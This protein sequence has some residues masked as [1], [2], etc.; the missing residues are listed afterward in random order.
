MG[1]DDEQPVALELLDASG[2]SDWET[3]N[4]NDRS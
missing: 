4:V 3:L 2:H 1:N